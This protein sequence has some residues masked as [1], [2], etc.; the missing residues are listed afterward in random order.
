MVN[1][2]GGS[3]SAAAGTGCRAPDAAIR[4]RVRAAARGLSRRRGAAVYRRVA[5]W[6]RLTPGACQPFGGRRV[7]TQRFSDRKSAGPEGLRVMVTGT[8]LRGEHCMVKT[9]GAVGKTTNSG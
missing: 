1:R 7:N 3:G 6:C 8:C 2:C 4:V 9:S 5:R